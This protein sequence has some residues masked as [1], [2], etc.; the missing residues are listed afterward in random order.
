[1]EDVAGR[2]WNGIWGRLARRDV[3]LTREVRWK[4]IARAGDSETGQVL[5]W[6]FDTET[7]ARAMVERL[8]AADAGGTWRQQ[9]GDA[10]SPPPR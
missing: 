2:W 8:L 7:E 6:E 5:R 9:T 4:V 3:W 1:M 10:A